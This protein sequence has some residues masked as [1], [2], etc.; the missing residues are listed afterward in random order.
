MTLSL[1]AAQEIAVVHIP[2]FLLSE[3]LRADYLCLAE[4]AAATAPRVVRGEAR[5]YA[6]HSACE[7]PARSCLHKC[8]PDPSIGMGD[9]HTAFCRQHACLR[10]L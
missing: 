2:I 1:Q 3:S 7:S 8:S 9:L 6:G 10:E 5:S 4:H